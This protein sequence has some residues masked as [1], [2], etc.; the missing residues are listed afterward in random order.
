[1]MMWN[2]DLKSRFACLA[3]AAAVLAGAGAGSVVAQDESPSKPSVA[4]KPAPKPLIPL[5]VTVVVSRFQ[6]EKRTGSLP[7]ILTVNANA[8]SPDIGSRVQLWIQE[9]RDEHL[10]YRHLR[11]RRTVLR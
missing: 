11:R 2:T 10:M 9:H 7:F 1:M 4:Q 8:V 3:V 6:G 5:K